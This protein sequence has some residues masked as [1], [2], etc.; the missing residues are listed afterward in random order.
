MLSNCNVVE[1]EG[2]ELSELEVLTLASA[3]RA[4]LSINHL[5]F[6]GII[7]SSSSIIPGGQSSIKAMISS[8]AT[9]PNLAELF[10][11]DRGINNEEASFIADILGDKKSLEHISFMH[12]VFTEEG[13]SKI[14]STF[15]CKVQ[16]I[17]RYGVP[18]LSS[19]LVVKA[20][21]DNKVFPELSLCIYDDDLLE[22][23]SCDNT[24]KVLKEGKF[25]S[26]HLEINALSEDSYFKISHALKQNYY[27]KELSIQ[28]LQEPGEATNS[29]IHLIKNNHNLKYLYLGDHLYNSHLILSALKKNNL[30]ETIKFLNHQFTSTELLIF[31]AALNTHSSLKRL[32][33]NV[34]I[35]DEKS[36][37]ALANI[38][39]NTSIVDLRLNYELCKATGVEVLTKAVKDHPYLISLSHHPSA[40]KLVSQAF[41]ENYKNF[42]RLCELIENKEFNKIKLIEI[43]PFLILLNYIIE[44]SD[45]KETERFKD[46]RYKITDYS[47]NNGYFPLHRISPKTL[48]QLMEDKG[49]GDLQVLPLELIFHILSF[50][51]LGDVKSSVK[52]EEIELCQ[53]YDNDA[54]IATSA[55]SSSKQGL[56]RK[57]IEEEQD[58]I[59][60]HLPPLVSDDEYKK[61]EPTFKKL[62]LESSPPIESFDDNKRNEEIEL[63][64][65][66]VKIEQGE[67]SQPSPLM[68]GSDDESQPNI[69]QL[70][71]TQLVSQQPLAQGFVAR[72]SKQ[73]ES[74]LIF[75]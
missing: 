8:L 3:L 40:G 31:A 45:F 20:I 33:L 56:K 6:A 46:I 39:A 37:I 17:T 66:E 55:T 38:I 50:L 74:E 26:L 32:E 34:D 36:A 53:V 1:L 5:S 61:K 18:C 57:E 4:N 24:L 70:P 28:D 35:L 16:L 13:A 71:F 60:T 59:Y 49:L 65:E 12:N 47:K 15:N 23:E 42:E 29:L 64:P 63:E 75:K 14:L 52:L 19:E 11:F 48:I 25:K 62:R 7:F 73:S 58:D 21:C 54:D 10:L 9:L 43:K 68:E 44:K 22:G 67:E 51:E 41:N 69:C 30:L 2:I 72:I 27:L